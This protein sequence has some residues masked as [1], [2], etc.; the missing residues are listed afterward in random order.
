VAF[1]VGMLGKDNDWRQSP[2]TGTNPS[3]HN[4]DHYGQQQL[5]HQGSTGDA[6]LQGRL[7]RLYIDAGRKGSDQDRDLESEVLVEAHAAGVCCRCVC[8][9]MRD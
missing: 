5:Q 4:G 3:Q 8:V 7:G 9:C 6:L 1:L 2:P